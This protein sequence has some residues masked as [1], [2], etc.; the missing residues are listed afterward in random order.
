LNELH[1]CLRGKNDFAERSKI[2]LDRCENNFVRILKIISN[3]VKNFDILP[4]SLNIYIII[5]IVRQNYFSDLY[6]VKI[7]DLSV[8]CSFRVIKKLITFSNI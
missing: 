1:V 7:L 2:L 5:L 8:K 6:P 4:T 3:A